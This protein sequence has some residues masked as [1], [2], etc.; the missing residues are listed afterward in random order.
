MRMLSLSRR[1][2]AWFAALLPMAAALAQADLV[3]SVTPREVTGILLPDE[4]RA[5][6]FVFNL[7]FPATFRNRAGR[8]VFV[9]DAANLTSIELRSASGEWKTAATSTTVHHTGGLD[10]IPTCDRVRPGREFRFSRL[11]GLFAVAKGGPPTGSVTMR[12]HF[13]SECMANGVRHGM[14]FVTNPILFGYA[15]GEQATRRPGQFEKE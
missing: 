4:P 8:P 12:F 10:R 3:I 15:T 11:G 14:T 6:E 9:A 1:N 2:H 7:L 5:K 13:F